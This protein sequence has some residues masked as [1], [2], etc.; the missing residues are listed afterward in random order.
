MTKND[1]AIKE[2]RDGLNC[3][4]S[5]L[6]AYTSDLKID[7][8]IALSI[9]TGFGGGMGRL[10]GTCG[11]V[12]GAFM[13][14]SVFTCRKYEQLNDRKTR[15][16][17]MIQS[18]NEKFLNIHKSTDC[19]DL[20]GCNLRTPE[21]QEYFKIHNLKETVCEKC[22]SNSVGILEEMFKV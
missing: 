12:T 8:N 19:R 5:V 22:I 2:F 15:S 11:A 9:S 3:A 6:S 20:L 16:M 18:F 7:K 14:I 17:E 10:Q 13:A 21:G 1:I 4:Q